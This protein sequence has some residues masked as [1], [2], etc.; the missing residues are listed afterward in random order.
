MNPPDA[1]LLRE[2]G[3]FPGVDQIHGVSYDGEHVWI[4]TGNQLQALD[5]EDGRVIRAL[6]VAAEA[7][8]AFDGRFLY[9]IAGEVIRKID[10][11][12][13][14]VHATLPV[15]PGERCSGM[16]WA[17]GR[18]WIG[19]HR[20][21]CIHEVD[22]DTGAVLRTL[23][24]DRYVTGVTWVEGELW[25]GTWEDDASELRQIDPVNGEVRQALR[26]PAGT[27]VSGLESDG[28][29]RLFCGGG[30]SGRLRAV[31]RPRR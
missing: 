22:P 14:S 5:P 15:P 6:P 25:H 21:R 27:M 3:P 7:G 17:E 13:G 31:R 4:A 2:Y 16:A 29:D 18:L 19:Q 12:T 26:M 30:R 23:N 8:T 11:L 20:G 10:P 28:A 9:Q 24:S 1:D